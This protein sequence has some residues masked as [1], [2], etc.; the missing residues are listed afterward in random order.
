MRV[1]RTPGGNYGICQIIKR[2]GVLFA[3]SALLA[4]NV[5]RNVFIKCIDHFCCVRKY[6]NTHRNTKTSY[7]GKFVYRQHLYVNVLFS[8]LFYGIIYIFP[9]ICMC[10]YV[11][12]NLFINLFLNVQPVLLDF[13]FCISSKIYSLL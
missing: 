6:S 4:R 3:I 11:R 2:N 10:T 13:F 7:I 1:Y 8:V 12:L 9:N 5:E